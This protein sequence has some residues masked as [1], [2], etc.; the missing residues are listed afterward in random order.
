MS[1]MVR[2]FKKMS[3]WDKFF[4]LFLG[5][6]VVY[7][8]FD[9]RTME[10]LLLGLLAVG[11]FII[12]SYKQLVELQNDIIESIANSNMALISMNRE[13]INRINEGD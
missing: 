7:A 12:E 11:Y 13:L 4:L 1:D 6:S 9:G 8:F 2:I 10:G 5:V 3:R